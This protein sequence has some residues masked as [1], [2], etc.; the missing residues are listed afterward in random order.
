M[1]FER[2]FIAEYFL[3]KDH[4]LKNTQKGIILH[5]QKYCD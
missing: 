5:F 1:S 3:L 4:D 2:S